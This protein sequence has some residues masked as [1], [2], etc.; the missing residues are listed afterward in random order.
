MTRASH[1]SGEHEREP[2]SFHR[3]SA[4]PNELLDGS[5]TCVLS[6]ESRPEGIPEN[7]DERRKRMN[8]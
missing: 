1:S 2:A 5:E 7:E 6:G 8:T 3:S 4:A